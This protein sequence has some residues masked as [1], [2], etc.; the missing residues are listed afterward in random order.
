[1]WIKRLIGEDAIAE[2]DQLGSRALLSSSVKNA[3]GR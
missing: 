1:L 3:G 2:I